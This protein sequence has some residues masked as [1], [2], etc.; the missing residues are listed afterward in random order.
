[1]RIF[2]LG[3]SSFDENTR[4]NDLIIKFVGAPSPQVNP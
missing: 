2:I 3:G 4:Q 1:M